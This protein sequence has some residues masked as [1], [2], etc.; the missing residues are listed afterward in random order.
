VRFRNTVHVADPN[1]AL[2][3]LHVSSYA[4]LVTDV[5]NPPVQR[6]RSGS[7]SDFDYVPGQSPFRPFADAFAGLANTLDHCLQFLW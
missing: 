1:G 2:Y 5:P 7:S 4:V 6:T 3:P